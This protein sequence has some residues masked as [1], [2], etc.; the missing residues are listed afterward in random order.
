MAIGDKQKKTHRIFFDTLWLQFV[1]CIKK[2][3]ITIDAKKHMSLRIVKFLRQLKT[4]LSMK[5][6][7]KTS[8]KLPTTPQQRTKTST[9]NGEQNNG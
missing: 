5:S 6:N 2:Q 8:E 9:T 4:M 1:P 3:K 7:L